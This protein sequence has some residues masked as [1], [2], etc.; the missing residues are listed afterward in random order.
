MRHVGLWVWCDV[1]T[2]VQSP[3]WMGKRSFRPTKARMS[4]SK[5]KMMLA[6]FFDW[7]RIVHH[8][9]LPRGQMVNKQLYQE[10]LARLRGAVRRKRPELRENRLGCFTTTMHRLTRC[11]LSAVI[12]RNIRHPLCSSH[13]IHRTYPQQTSSCFPNLKK[14]TGLNG[15]RFQTIEEIQGNAIR[16][17]RAIT[18]R[19][20]QEAFQQWTNRWNGVSAV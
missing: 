16:E 20:F 2:K 15:R 12:W 3:Q 1:E 11:F 7:K 10:V 17:L 18:E 5:I 8:E 13:P 14:K 4:R 9:F 6:V 19:A